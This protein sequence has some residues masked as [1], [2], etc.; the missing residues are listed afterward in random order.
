MPVTISL[1]IRLFRQDDSGRVAFE[2][3]GHAFIIHESL[4]KAFHESLYRTALYQI[5][6]ERFVKET[7]KLL[8][9]Q[10]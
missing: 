1:P 8:T 9:H 7:S 5:L 3:V 6:G 4:G 2:V 10:D